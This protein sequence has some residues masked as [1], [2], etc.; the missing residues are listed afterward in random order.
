MRAAVRSHVPEFLKLAPLAAFVCS[1]VGVDILAIRV[2]VGV[3]IELGGHAGDGGGEL[4]NL[5]LHRCQ[6]ICCLNVGCRVDG[7]IGCTCAGELLDVFADLVTVVCHLV[8]RFVPIAACCPPSCILFVGVGGV[9]NFFEM[10]FGEVKI[11]FGCCGLT[12]PR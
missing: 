2:W 10:C 1:A 7:I 4:F 11:S 5:R 12:L 3:A 8:G 6:L 9:D